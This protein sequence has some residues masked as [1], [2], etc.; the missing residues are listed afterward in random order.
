MASEGGAA[1]PRYTQ[2]QATRWLSRL[3]RRMREHGQ[4]VFLIE[5]L[6]PS[7]LGGAGR[8]WGYALVSRVVTGI[9]LAAAV[10]LPLGPDAR[11]WAPALG[12]GL[13]LIAAT[14]E[15]RRWRAGAR[16]PE[17]KTEPGRG[18]IVLLVL[19]SG[20]VLGAAIGMMVTPLLY[21]FETR[22][23]ESDV[24]LVLGVGGLV[25]GLLIAAILV[26]ALLLVWW[27]R[28]RW[29]PPGSWRTLS[30]VVG[31]LL[32]FELF[33]FGCGAGL[34]ALDLGSVNQLVLLSS[35]AGGLIWGL[36]RARQ[37]ALL[38]VEAVETLAWSWAHARR[39]AFVGL[40]L[41]LIPCLMVAISGLIGALA[42][43][44][45]GKAQTGAGEVL[46]IVLL[47]GLAFGLP[48]ALVGGV[49]SG[50]R[51]S[52]REMKTTPNQGIRLSLWNAAWV[53]PVVLLILGPPLAGGLAFLN[54]PAGAVRGLLAALTFALLASLWHGGLDALSHYVLRYMLS[55]EGAL[56][57]NLAGFLDYAALE[58]G[59]LQKVGGGYMFVHRYLL[60]H[61]A[62]MG[63]GPATAR[64]SEEPAPAAASG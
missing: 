59:F 60:E 47:V 22:E 37:A 15:G 20:V 46:T 8:R 24:A 13:G 18:Q 63:E 52:P 55:R 27:R 61:F 53:G 49:F 36:R 48:F 38:D 40:K 17:T 45:R 6:Q 2:E 57:W 32:V 42:A 30:S 16:A 9:V 64:A 33:A 29:R 23:M 11:A 54:G 58:L 31:F 62:T 5:Q 56:P 25:I 28:G 39:G 41:G 4:T 3:A 12:L 7:W 14:L 44:V 51:R 35:L 34:L 43:L 19:A 10:A 50:F 1:R 21:L 26:L